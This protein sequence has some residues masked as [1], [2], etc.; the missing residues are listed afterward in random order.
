MHVFASNDPWRILVPIQIETVHKSTTRISRQGIQGFL[1]RIIKT[2]P[3]IPNDL[4]SQGG[5]RWWNKQVLIW[6][7]SKKMHM[8][9]GSRVWK[10]DQIWFC[11]EPWAI[12]AR[13]IFWSAVAWVKKTCVRLLSDDMVISRSWSTKPGSLS[14]WRQGRNKL[15]RWWKM[16]HDY[17]ISHN[18]S[19]DV[20]RGQ[21]LQTPDNSVR[22]QAETMRRTQQ[23]TSHGG[24]WF[25]SV[26]VTVNTNRWPKG[27][28]LKILSIQNGWS[29]VPASKAGRARQSHYWDDAK[30]LDVACCLGKRWTKN[31]FLNSCIL[32]Y[33]L[34]SELRTVLGSADVDEGVRRSADYW[35]LVL[36]GTERKHSDQKCICFKLFEKKKL[37]QPSKVFK[38]NSELHKQQWNPKQVATIWQQCRSLLS[39]LDHG[40]KMHAEARLRPS[41]AAGHPRFWKGLCLCQDG[42]TMSAQIRNFIADPYLAELC[43]T[44]S[45]WKNIAKRTIV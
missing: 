23:V 22:Q 5:D 17:R 12:S 11:G 2:H 24:D 9:F 7:Q 31:M 39:S 35:Y 42:G 20:L 37:K 30:I 15:L 8:S 6:T 38:G 14:C 25:S 18:R 10:L 32:G 33:D 34:T 43:L 19:D 36:L 29:K 27:W 3:Q 44:Y 45:I 28:I 13:Q 21:G 16:W 40:N 1:L 26:M 4:S 41:A